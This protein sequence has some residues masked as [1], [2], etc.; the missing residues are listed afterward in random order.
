MDRTGFISC[1]STTLGSLQKRR[2]MSVAI[3]EGMGVI[4]GL[5]MR[6][7]ISPHAVRARFSSEAVHAQHT[8]GCGYLHRQ[9][10]GRML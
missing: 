8:R 4:C 9:Y 5:A 3:S 1:Y 10:M 6:G 7:L 2:Q